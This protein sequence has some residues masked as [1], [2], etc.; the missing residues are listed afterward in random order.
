MELKGNMK[1][2]Q[3][4]VQMTREKLGRDFKF[5]NAFTHICDTF[6]EFHKS[7]RD[8]NDFTKN[9]LDTNFDVIPI[10]YGNKESGKVDYKDEK[11]NEWIKHMM[12]IHS[13]HNSDDYQELYKLCSYTYIQHI[14]SKNLI[15][16]ASKHIEKQQ[17]EISKSIELIEK[18][19]IVEQQ[20]TGSATIK[21]LQEDNEKLKAQVRKL[22]R[23]NKKMKYELGR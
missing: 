6:D 4:L 5:D 15:K 7:N 8:F 22:T 10:L 18:L 9:M 2:I 12:A 19:S 11:M 1:D 17:K 16:K 13:L 20:P 23:E 14:D 21:Y 3:G